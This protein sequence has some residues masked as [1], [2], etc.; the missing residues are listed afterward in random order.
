VDPVVDCYPTE[1][2]PKRLHLRRERL[3]RL[4]G[5]P[6]PD[7]DVVRILT[8]LGLAVTP[9]S[10]GWDIVVAL[11][12]VDLLREADLIEEV[13]RHY[14]FDRLAP[15]FPPVTQPAPPPDP[16][17]MRDQFV[18]R[19]L[20][21]AGLSEAVTFGFIEARAAEPFQSGAGGAMPIAN[22]LSAKF[23]TL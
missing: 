15:T 4:F 17:T 22:P 6:V 19:V 1:R 9:A 12:R 20:T 21:A 5:I 10:D 16:R 13:G 14:G 18:R 11:F 2:R 3:A 7:A 23:D 8:R